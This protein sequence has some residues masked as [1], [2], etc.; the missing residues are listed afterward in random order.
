MSTYLGAAEAASLVG[1]APRYL[2]GDSFIRSVHRENRGGRFEEPRVIRREYHH[3]HGEWN[4]RREDWER[5]HPGEDWHEREQRRVNWETRNPGIPF[6]GAEAV[7]Q[8]LSNAG[9]TPK[10]ALVPAP[11]PTTLDRQVLP[12]NTGTTPVP[13]GLTAQITSRPQRV[14]F[15]PKR[16]FVSA[17][18]VGGGGSAANWIINDI[19]IGNRSQFAQSGAL[20][21][22]MFATTAIDSYVTF[23]T[24][25]TAMDVVMI[26]T[27]QGAT[28]GGTPFY[29][30]IIGEAAM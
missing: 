7:V 29:G 21:G 16:V 1:A 17:A 26:V 25:Q 8:M 5:I 11:G 13:I 18:D 23:E 22:D 3:P 2:V 20:P 24:A 9:I 30:S 19:T 28:E 10:A 14:A 12:M 4:L 6:V 27:Y 15:R